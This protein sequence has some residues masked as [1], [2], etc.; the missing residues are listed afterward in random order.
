MRLLE[1]IKK[2]KLTISTCESCTGGL[3]GYVIT[4]TSGSSEYYK[5]GLITYSNET[6][7]KLLDIPLSYIDGFGAVSQEVSRQMSI[8]TNKIFDTDIS[9]SITG[10]AG[11]NDG[12]K[13]GLVFISVY[14]KSDLKNRTFEMKFTGD[15]DNIRN[16]IIYY[17]LYKIEF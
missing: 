3:L 10:Y 15:R 1:S 14:T 9:I 6:K 11:P 5:G 2:N 8:K 13:N 12:D 4:G 7:S 16:K 17:I